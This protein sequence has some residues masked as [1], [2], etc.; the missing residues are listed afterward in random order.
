[1]TCFAQDGPHHASAWCVHCLREEVLALKCE[2][3]VI[4]EELH[5]ATE[6]AELL[7]REREARDD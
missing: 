3:A 6:Q 1:M 4:K 7:I 2:L 5:Q